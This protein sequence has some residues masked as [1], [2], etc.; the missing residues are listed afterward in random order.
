MKEELQGKLVEILTS[1]QGAVGRASD[2]AMAE[3]PDI[4]QSYIA[5]GRTMSVIGACVILFFITLSIWGGY[6]INKAVGDGYWEGVGWAVGGGGIFLCLFATLLTL[7]SYVLV[8]AAP[9]VWLLKEIAG[10]LK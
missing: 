5:Y 3:L 6:R 4:A 10:M 2:F 7:P 8:W 9:K 1:V